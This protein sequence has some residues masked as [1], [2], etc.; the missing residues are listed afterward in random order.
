MVQILTEA[1][2]SMIAFDHSWKNPQYFAYIMLLFCFMH[3]IIVYII[4]TLIKGIFWEVFFTVNQIFV[5]REEETKQEEIKEEK[6]QQK[7][8]EIIEI[9][10]LIAA[11]EYIDPNTILKRE[12]YENKLDSVI[13]Q[14]LRRDKEHMKLSKSSKK[15]TTSKKLIMSKIVED[16]Q[17]PVE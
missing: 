8:N 5:D 15:L 12:I 1:G 10:M 3:I 17:I 9:N 7:A 11:Q 6:N 2:W 13:F 14:K 4:A 16:Y